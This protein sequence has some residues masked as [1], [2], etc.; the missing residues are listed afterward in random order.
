MKN[1]NEVKL[2]G[3]WMLREAYEG[4]RVVWHKFQVSDFCGLGWFS[5]QGEDMR[6]N[7]LKGK[8]VQNMF[9]LRYLKASQLE[10]FNKHL[11]LQLQSKR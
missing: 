7:R 8:S 1:A 11:N 10:N 9:T 4:E 2:L 6:I 5:S 3:F